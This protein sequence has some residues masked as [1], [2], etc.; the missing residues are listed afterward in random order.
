MHFIVATHSNMAAGIKDAVSR[1][2]GA[3]DNISY[4]TA[5]VRSDDFQK[6]FLDEL[7]RIPDDQIIM[8]TDLLA[9]SVNQ[10]AMKYR[11]PKKLDVVTGV[12][13]ALALRVLSIDGQADIAAQLRECVEQS[14]QQMIFMNKMIQ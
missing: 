14:R 3:R 5:Y 8:L 2:I 7:A 1:M 9:G 6:E 10:V 4:L 13:L 12:N 11:G